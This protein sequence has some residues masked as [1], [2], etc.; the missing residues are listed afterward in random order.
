[1][2]R[3]KYVLIGCFLVVLLLVI[4]VLTK[5]SNQVQE[6]S[7]KETSNGIQTNMEEEIES[8]VLESEFK[9]TEGSELLPGEVVL[10]FNPKKHPFSSQV[11]AD[12]YYYTYRKLISSNSLGNHLV[13]DEVLN[14]LKNERD[15]ESSLGQVGLLEMV[16][17]VPHLVRFL[18]NTYSPRIQRK[19]A[20][21]LAQ[22]GQSDGFEFL[23]DNYNSENLS[24][25]QVLFETLTFYEQVEYVPRIREMLKQEMQKGEWY[26]RSLARILAYFGDES[27]LEFYLPKL[28]NEI[29]IGIT[30]IELL[31]N[32]KS[33]S[34]AELLNHLY[35]NADNSLINL[36]AAF[37]LTKQG[38]FEYQ[39]KIVDTA[40]LA[41]SMPNPRH[42][43]DDFQKWSSKHGGENGSGI[44][45]ATRYL[46][47]IPTLD[48]VGT[49][50][51]IAS[52]G[53]AYSRAA[54]IGLAEMGTRE[55]RDALIRLVNEI[56]GISLQN[57]LANALVL[58]S[59]KEATA[60]ALN[61]FDWEKGKYLS[62]F[63]AETKGSNGLFRERIKRW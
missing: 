16:E 27:A 46:A 32:I 52:S 8:M 10:R 9:I 42:S 4:L 48:S 39:E 12:A 62:F 2:N 45:A 55:S 53:T 22:F 29:D 58:Y 14:N 38:E 57:Y 30:D 23:I 19:S 44:S 33:K 51:V 25:N 11:S 17:A 41:L 35:T 63:L 60:A 7:F 26:G 3:E 6:K 56:R 54:I 50:E 61:L 20:R 13:Y 31:A 49:L 59:D 37:A 34:L 21:L 36:A 24:V 40:L 28:T 47:Q 1:M 43:P 15:L 18:N 5:V